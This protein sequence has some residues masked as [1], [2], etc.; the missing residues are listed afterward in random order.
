MPSEEP[1]S[2]T[3]QAELARTAAQAL[4][5]A[6]YSHIALPLEGWVL[7]QATP[8]PLA[9]PLYWAGLLPLALSQAKTPD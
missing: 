7:L 1:L 9:R 8:G 6:G 4:T 2:I 3:V 5:Q